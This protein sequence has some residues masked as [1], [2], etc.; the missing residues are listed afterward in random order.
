MA[1]KDISCKHDLQVY[2][3]KHI[4]NTKSTK[5]WKVTLFQNWSLK[6]T[7]HLFMLK[8]FCVLGFFF[9]RENVVC[10]EKAI[11]KCNG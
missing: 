8:G 9:N 1:T 11:L 6:R 5:G 4:R 3:Q 2:D 10:F 7:N